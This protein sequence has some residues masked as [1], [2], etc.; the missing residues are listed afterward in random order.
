LDNSLTAMASPVLGKIPDLR[1]V[2]A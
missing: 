2:V 1:Y